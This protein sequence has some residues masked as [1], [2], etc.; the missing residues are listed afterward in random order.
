MHD[1][2]KK[3]EDLTKVDKRKFNDKL[4]KFQTISHA[5]E[6][7]LDQLIK[8]KKGASARL[9]DPMATEQ[10]QKVASL[11]DKEITEKELTE[12]KTN[13]GEDKEFIAKILDKL[14]PE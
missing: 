10:D 8:L 6:G 14:H 7:N 13:I 1:E 4:A 2:M 9:K 3:A 12:L 11:I 5:L